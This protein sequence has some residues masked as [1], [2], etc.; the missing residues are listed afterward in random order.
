MPAA[1]VRGTDVLALGVAVGPEVKKYLAM[2][3][4]A[5]LDGEFTSAVD[6]IAWLRTQMMLATGDER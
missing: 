2:A 1:L 4:D 3:Y 5:Q 6:G